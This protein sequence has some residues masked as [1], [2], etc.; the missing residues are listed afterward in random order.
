MTKLELIEIARYDWHK[1][2]TVEDKSLITSDVID[3]ITIIDSDSYHVALE[4]VNPSCINKETALKM[5]QYD[6][7]IYGLL[8]KQLQED[9]DIIEATIA[10]LEKLPES[11]FENKTALNYLL[12]KTNANRN[13]WAVCDIEKKGLVIKRDVNVRKYIVYGYGK[14]QMSESQNPSAEFMSKTFD[15]LAMEVF[16][17]TK[18][19]MP[20]FMTSTDVKHLD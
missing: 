13:S 18:Q 8:T 10:D 7:K 9:N 11:F 4:G 20:Y 14:K 12:D 15:S 16:F 1:L 5:L 17:L 2:K 19:L 3:N 6:K